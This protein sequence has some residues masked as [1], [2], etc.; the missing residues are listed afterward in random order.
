[1]HELKDW[2]A[3]EFGVGIAQRLLERRVYLEEVSLEAEYC[4]QF[5]GTV[6]EVAA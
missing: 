5:R 4:E 6:E 1:M 3:R 2:T